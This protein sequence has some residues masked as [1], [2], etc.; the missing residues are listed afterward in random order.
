MPRRLTALALVLAGAKAALADNMKMPADSGVSNRVL[1][2]PY[3]R[4]GRNHCSVGQPLSKTDLAF[5]V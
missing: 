1:R 5:S 3:Y 2:R 4:R